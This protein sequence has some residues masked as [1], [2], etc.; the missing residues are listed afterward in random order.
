M[1]FK[2]FD[3]WCNARACDGMWSIDIAIVSSSILNQMFKTAIWRRRKKWKDFEPDAT[4][5]VERCKQHY[6]GARMDEEV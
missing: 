2:E 4:K 3:E 5:I 6:C 1:T